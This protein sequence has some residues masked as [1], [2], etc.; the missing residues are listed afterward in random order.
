MA[1]REDEDISH[2]GSGQRRTECQ[3][4]KSGSEQERERGGPVRQTRGASWPLTCVLARGNRYRPVL[5]HGKGASL[6]ELGHLV[7]WNFIAALEDSLDLTLLLYT[8]S[9]PFN[10]NSSP[11]PPRFLSSRRPVRQACFH[12]HSAEEKSG[13]QRGRP[14]QSA[15]AAGWRSEAPTRSA[16]PGR[17]GGIQEPLAAAPLGTERLLRPWR[18][19]VPVGDVQYK[20]GLKSNL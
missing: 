11:H 14:A 13:F 18:P 20:T 8:K 17:R 3:E 5:I 7:G 4:G 15:T 9:P 1:L 16:Q 2:P 6:L 10:D 19:P 12:P